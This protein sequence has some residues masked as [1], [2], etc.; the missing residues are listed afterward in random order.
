LLDAFLV[1]RLDDREDYGEERINILAMCG[2]TILHDFM[3]L[4]P[5]AAVAF[6]SFQRDGRK[7]MNKTFI[8]AKIASDGRAVEVLEDGTERPFPVTPMRPMTEEQIA[9]AAAADPDARPMTTEELGSARRVPRTKTIRR[10][11]G[12][13]QEEFAADF[14][15]TGPLR[16]RPTRA[17][18]FDRNRPRPRWCAARLG[19]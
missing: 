19:R 17:R 12:L 6:E 2:E 16:T 4:P 18:L 9:T 11:L 13:T 5:C 14:H 3:Y 1:E 8:T 10:V 15:I 7:N